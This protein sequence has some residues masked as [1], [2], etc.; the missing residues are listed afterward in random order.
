MQV[1]KF[2]ELYNSKVVEMN[3]CSMMKFFDDNTFQYPESIQISVDTGKDFTLS[4]ESDF[5]NFYSDNDYVIYDS[6]VDTINRNFGETIVSRQEA[7]SFFLSMKYGLDIPC[8]LIGKLESIY[9]SE[10]LDQLIDWFRPMTRDELE[11]ILNNSEFVLKYPGVL[12]YFSLDATFTPLLIEHFKKGDLNLDGL[13]TVVFD[14]E[15]CKNY[16]E[17]SASVPED[18]Y[19]FSLSKREDFLQVQHLLEEIDFPEDILHEYA[20]SEYLVDILEAYKKG[21]YSEEFLHNYCCNV[22]IP[23]FQ[24]E[25]IMGEYS[26]GN[27]NNELLQQTKGNFYLTKLLAD[28]QAYKIQ[29]DSIILNL[30]NA[31]ALEEIYSFSVQVINALLSKQ[32]T[33]LD[34]LRYSAMYC[35]STQSLIREKFKKL[36]SK[37]VLSF[38]TF[39]WAALFDEIYSGTQ[40]F[41]LP[42]DIGAFTYIVDREKHFKMITTLNVLLDMQHVLDIID[43]SML[44]ATIVP[45][46]MEDNKG[47]FLIP[48]DCVSIKPSAPA[49]LD[50]LKSSLDNYFSTFTEECYNDYNSETCI[51]SSNFI[52]LKS[53]LGLDDTF[54][55]IFENKNVLLHYDTIFYRLNNDLKDFQEILLSKNYKA[56]L[57][58]LNAL[59]INDSVALVFLRFVDKII[60]LVCKDADYKFSDYN[61]ELLTSDFKI[62]VIGISGFMGIGV[63]EF[64]M[65]F[66]RIILKLSKLANIRLVVDRPGSNRVILKG[67]VL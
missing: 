12:K 22:D 34:Y 48:K 46:L 14:K 26:S 55:A 3:G 29:T 42:P 13:N 17:D 24:L 9:T 32:I 60:K 28:L 37:T 67:W 50:L 44:G 31:A 20:E 40:T 38:N 10:L 35:V 54:N 36:C 5:T 16:L 11:C 30:Q 66:D 43:S 2:L 57:N 33:K 58:C 18:E 19:S 56:Y 47:L 64:I 23:S 1:Q 61:A 6:P 7:Y 41:D 15:L 8:D 45:V 27:F 51:T 49:Y 59:Q 4:L 65:N 25:L 62:D 21:I 63:K 52:L 53:H 39:C